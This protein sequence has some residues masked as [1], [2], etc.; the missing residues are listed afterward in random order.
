[1][2][3]YLPELDGLKEI[4][5]Y[6]KA[7]HARNQRIV[8]ASDLVIAF[9]EKNTGG[10]WDTIKRARRAGLPVKIIRPKAIPG[11]Q[12]GTGERQEPQRSQREKGKG[13]FQLKRISLGSYALRLWRYF[14]PIEWVDFMNYKESAPGK[15]ADMMLPDFLGFFR[16]YQ[17][18]TI[19]AITQ[20]PKSIRNLDKEHPMDQ[21][22]ATVAQELQVDYLEMFKPWN[23]RSRGR[24]ADHPRLELTAV[25]SDYAG[26]VVYVLDDVTTSNRTL[27]TC[28]RALMNAGIHAHAVAWVYYS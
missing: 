3:E 20:A 16:Q 10:T 21:V 25:V 13:P 9:T 1:V 2:I 7:Y 18:G 8:D 15:C 5:E 22:C 17:Y 23:K 24:H 4:Q 14:E 12:Q 11:V 19:H 26:K 6:T 28:V 27:R